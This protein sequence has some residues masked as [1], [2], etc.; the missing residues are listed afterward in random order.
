[1]LSSNGFVDSPFT[2]KLDCI[3]RFASLTISYVKLHCD[4]AMAS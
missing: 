1:M 3:Y 2:A 4:Y